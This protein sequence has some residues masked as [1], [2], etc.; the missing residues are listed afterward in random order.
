LGKVCPLATAKGDSMAFMQFTRP[1][2]SPVVIN[3][4]EVVDFAPVPPDGALAGPLKQ[5]TRIKFKNGT[6][7]DVKELVEEVTKRLSV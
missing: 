4:A 6:H 7:Q 1:D 3:S 2:D 5:G